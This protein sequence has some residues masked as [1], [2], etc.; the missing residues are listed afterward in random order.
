LPLLLATLLL[1]IDMVEYRPEES[2]QNLM[3]QSIHSEP[4][5][6]RSGYSTQ[7]AIS[8]TAFAVEIPITSFEPEEIHPFEVGLDLDLDLGLELEFDLPLIEADVLRTP[9]DPYAPRR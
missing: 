9:T 5:E 4:L 8:T 7:E 2:N 3:D 6:A 1:S